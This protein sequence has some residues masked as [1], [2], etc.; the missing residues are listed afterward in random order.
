VPTLTL[1]LPDEAAQEAFGA[2][3]ASCLQPGLL[4]FLRGEL[5]A[6]KTTLTRGIARGLGHRGAV[7]SPTY[8]LVEPYRELRIPLY[9][10]DLYR[11]GDAEELE[12]LGIRDYFSGQA[13]VVVEWPDRGRGVLPEPDLSIQLD[14]LP[15]GRRLHLHAHSAA[16]SSCLRALQSAQVAG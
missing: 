6:G 1:T 9:H 10:F 14:V 11:L 16:G 8:T 2:R 3:L 7:K 13:V 12:Y 15:A 4:L 5:G